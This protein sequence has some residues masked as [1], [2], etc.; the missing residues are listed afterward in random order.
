MTKA[1]QARSALTRWAAVMLGLALTMILLA[2]APPAHAHDGT[3]EALSLAVEE[4][5]LVGTTLVAF[6]DVG[7]EDTSGDG[8]IDEAEFNEQKS[9]VSTNL[10]SAVRERTGLEVNGVEVSIVGAGLAFPE[11]DTETDPDTDTDPAAASEYIGLAFVSGA[12]DGE[13]SELSFAWDFNSPDDTVVVSDT[14]RAVVGSLSADGTVTFTLDA[15]TTATSFLHQ[16][17]EHIRS[18]L[19]HTLFLIVL[20]LGVVGAQLTRTTAWRVI[21]LVTAFTAGHAVS[22]CL[23]YFDLLSVPA[24]IVEPA[25]A[26]SITG[27][28]ALALRSKPG[29]HPWWIA[30][31]VG[32]VHGLGFA[33]SLADL[34]LATAD[35]ATALLVFN[36]G[37]DL[38]QVAV[39][40]AVLATYALL[41]RLLPRRVQYIR[42]AASLAIGAVGLFWTVTRLLP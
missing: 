16:G 11:T 21:K 38:A 26:L 23:A 5:R 2:A 36:L 20:T 30:G 28:A 37:I 35:H 4:D 3:S 19:D 42:I 8:L 31:V 27:A 40:A 32:L 29:R 1:V 33:S 13:M 12:F 22:L 41:Q 39:V 25:I 15:W 7:L 6:T 34:G 18:G 10:V 17:I 24:Q 9:A 14:E